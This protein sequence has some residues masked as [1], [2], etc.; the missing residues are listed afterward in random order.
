M[1]TKE[2]FSKYNLI[3]IN[4][5]KD[6]I[7]SKNNNFLMNCEVLYNESEIDFLHK[8]NCQKCNGKRCPFNVQRRDING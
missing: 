4:N 6:F 1:K 5:L 3:Q 8:I 7:K 2:M